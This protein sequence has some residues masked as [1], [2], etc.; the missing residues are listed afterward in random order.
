VNGRVPPSNRDLARL[1]LSK[2]KE[3][4]ALAENLHASGSV[5]FAYGHLVFALEE[6]GKG[7]VRLLIELGVVHWRDD[8]GGIRLEERILSDRGSHKFKTYVG[9]SLAMAGAVREFVD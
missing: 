4:L 8:F 9:G 2:A 3:H 5:A 7:A 1:A 6:A